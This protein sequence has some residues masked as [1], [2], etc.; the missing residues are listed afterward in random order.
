VNRIQISKPRNAPPPYENRAPVETST[1]QLLAV[2]NGLHGAIALLGQVFRRLTWPTILGMLGGAAACKFL[3][4][5]AA[6]VDGIAALG[7]AGACAQVGYAV[8]HRWRRVVVPRPPR[9]PAARHNR[10]TAGR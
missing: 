7:F 8:Q 5:A 4:V 9:R 10:A 3:N 1:D 2:L 6:W